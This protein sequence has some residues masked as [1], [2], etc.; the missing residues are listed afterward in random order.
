M[1]RR[2]GGLQDDMATD[3]ANH[4]VSSV[5]AKSVIRFFSITE[6]ANC[7]LSG[8]RFCNFQGRFLLIKLNFTFAPKLC[9]LAGLY[10]LATC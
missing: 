9:Y 8:N 5:S 3:L 10:A 1:S 2:I 4:L 7:Y 6:K